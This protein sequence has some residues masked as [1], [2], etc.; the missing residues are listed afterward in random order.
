MLLKWKNRSV[1]SRAG[2]RCY[3]NGTGPTS[4]HVFRRDVH[5]TDW[6]EDQRANCLT[7]EE[8]F[9]DAAR[10]RTK[11]VRPAWT[12]TR[13]HAAGHVSFDGHSRA[14]VGRWIGAAGNTRIGPTASADRHRS[15]HA[16]RA[17]AA[18]ENYESRVGRN[19]RVRCKSRLTNP[20]NTG[21]ASYQTPRSA[22]RSVVLSM[23]NEA[24]V[25][26]SSARIA[27]ALRMRSS[28][29]CSGSASRLT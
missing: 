17:T 20:F 25:E 2:L 4:G 28:F 27:K 29:D 12:D 7:D 18:A 5:W 21:M 26:P 11:H 24:S 14:L 10:T 19:K 15:V 6:Q 9:A 16:G 13:G 3:A 8:R 22:S 23:P 1:S